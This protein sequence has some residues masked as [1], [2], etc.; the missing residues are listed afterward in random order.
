[1]YKIL[2]AIYAQVVVCCLDWRMDS[3]R[4]H[5]VVMERRLVSHVR[6]VI[7]GRGQVHGLASVMENGQKDNLPVKVHVMII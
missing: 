2:V 6:K 5:T 1:M 3:L 4:L 7:N